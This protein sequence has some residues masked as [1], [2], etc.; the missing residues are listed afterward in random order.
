VLGNDLLEA[1][2]DVN[3]LARLDLDVGCL[4]SKPADSWWIRIFAFGSERGSIVVTSNR[5]FEQWG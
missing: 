3:H 4:P 5:G 2:L 1:P